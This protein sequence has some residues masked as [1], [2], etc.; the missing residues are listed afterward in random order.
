MLDDDIAR[1]SERVSCAV[2]GGLVL[3][4]MMWN[5]TPNLNSGGTGLVLRLLTVT[6]SPRT[7]CSYSAHVLTFPRP[8]KNDAHTQ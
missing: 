8:P 4:E 3:P 6:R 2:G 5:L 1:A 7:L